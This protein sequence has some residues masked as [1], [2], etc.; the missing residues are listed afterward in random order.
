VH[1]APFGTLLFRL[2]SLTRTKETVV[3]SE[4]TL[5]PTLVAFW[6]LEPSDPREI[7]GYRLRARIGEGGM[8]RVYFSNTPGGRPVAIKVIK[9]EYADDP[10]FRRRFGREIATAQRVQGYYTAP[11]IDA[12]PQAPQPWLATAYVPGPSLRE[13][14]GT[15]G[16]LPVHSVMVLIAGVAE[17]LQ[18]I[19][20]AGVVHR[21]LKPSNVILAEGGPRVIDFGI[22]RALDDTSANQPSAQVGTPAY[23]APE[24]VRGGA[25]TPAID[26][27]A[28][29]GLAYHAATGEL[30]FG[31]GAD[32]AVLYRILE[33]EPNLAGCPEPLRPLV[34]RCLDK[35]PVHRPSPAEVIELCRQESSGARLP[36]GDGWLPPRVAAAVGEIAGARVP[37]V[38]RKASARR[39]PAV[40][41][42]AAG[43]A[44]LAAAAV[45]VAVWSGVI[46]V[47]GGASRG[48]TVGA[49]SATTTTTSVNRDSS[50]LGQYDL[51]L[52]EGYGMI[53]GDPAR[54][55]LAGGK[56]DPDLWLT[57]A[58]NLFYNRNADRAV[59]LPG[60]AK[61]GYE[62]C[63]TDT[64][65]V[66]NWYFPR[67]QGGEYF[68]VISS[69]RVGL[70]NVAK[71]PGSD[72]ARQYYE[73]SLTLWRLAGS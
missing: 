37:A 72:N 28:L 29:G 2:L 17:A 43:A 56:P 64:R 52:S 18:S 21:D 22:A 15:Y 67:F 50:Y 71:I 48:S 45:L 19:H 33:Q 24:Q 34:K 61:P 13:T 53:L 16:P 44:I 35:L 57:S 36:T 5:T 69:G 63:T 27:F 38:P 59:V 1:H 70:F 32:P 58:G 23:M 51:N 62:S 68:C 9:A 31:S 4:T 7:G 12:G 66:S 10:A 73:F 20:A 60:Y 26:V 3:T 46:G 54:P 8:G 6:P 14:V 30:P 41:L 40:L 39:W 11:V 47:P 65:Y 55:I 25:V 42:A 49:A